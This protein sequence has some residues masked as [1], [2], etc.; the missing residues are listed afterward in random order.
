MRILLTTLGSLG[1]LHPYIAVAR[2]LQER[3]HGVTL[4][5]SE[6]YRAKV[7]G[8]GLS[9]HAIRPDLAGLIDDP[10]SIRKA[11]HP[12][13]GTEYIIRRI[14]LPSLVQSFEDTLAAARDADLIVGHPVAFATPLAAEH[15]RKPW[16]SVAL[17]PISLFS[18]EDPPSISGAAF[19]ERFRNSA[20]GFWR[21]F[22]NVARFETRAWGKPIRSLRKKLGL[23]DD[24]NPIL[25]GT[26]SPHGTH[27][28]FSRVFA[29][30]RSDWP[31]RTTVTGFP[32]YDRLEPGLGLS[33]DMRA[34]LAA[35]PAPVVFTLGSSAV[36][37]AG[38]FYEEGA[39]AALKAGRRAVLLTGHGA[40][41]RPR[42][43]ASDD[44]LMADYAPYSELFPYAAAVVHQ[45]GV[46]TTAQALRAGCPMIVMPYSHDQPDNARRVAGLGVA[47]VVRRDRFRA[48]AA[49]RE[50]RELLG[51]GYASNAR[52]VAE[53]MAP[54]DGVAAACRAIEET[55]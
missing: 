1:D 2:G 8:E 10:A 14:F 27:A 7:E 19:L 32:F 31:A 53:E 35:G 16:V 45:G 49:A 29:R 6:I 38:Q 21:F 33:R 4:A 51:G 26:L 34:F 11:F 15:L 40:A 20:P 30:P 17:A 5:S 52:R 41:N 12:R 13:T 48:A 24:R 28:W 44:I 46:G 22:W 54:E 25:D 23:R 9:F 36:F 37:D 43:Q 50:L 42:I 55:I 47:R 39:R 18:A 3:G